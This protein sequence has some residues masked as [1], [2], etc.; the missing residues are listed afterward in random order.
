MLKINPLPAERQEA[1]DILRSL[2]GPLQVRQDCLSCEIYE[3]YES[4]GEILYVEQW[5]SPEALQRHIQSALYMRILT[6]MEL[7]AKAP[8]IWF[9]EVA[10]SKGMELIEALRSCE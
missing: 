3:A 7:A 2:R 1:L 4:E 8:E 9:H 5:R 10:E 6:A